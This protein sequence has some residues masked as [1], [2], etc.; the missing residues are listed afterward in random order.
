MLTKIS[1][2]TGDPGTPDIVIP[3]NPGSPGTPFVPAWDEIVGTQT[4]TEC[5]RFG[6]EVNIHTG[7]R[8]VFCVQQRTRTVNIVVHHPAVPAVPPTPPTPPIVIPGRPAN[9]V[10]DFNLGWNSGAVSV[11]SIDGG[12]A[13]TF[14]CPVSIV[15]A[16]VGLAYSNPTE[17]YREIPFA[18]YFNSGRF[19]VLEMGVEKTAFAAY[20]DEDTF[21]IMRAG[22]VVTY[23]QNDAP[24]YTSRTT[25]ESVLFV[26]CSLYCGGDRIL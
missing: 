22:G 15:G 4:I 1:T 12:C 3:G 10:T 23:A 9:L 17:H 13:L 14:S 11:L 20:T 7:Q 26:D 19:R 5:A 2:V 21:R 18:L 25:C 8:E 24:F 6:S 16:V